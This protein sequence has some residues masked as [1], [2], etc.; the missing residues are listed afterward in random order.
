LKVGN[1]SVSMRHCRDF[2]G[3]HHVEVGPASDA[4]KGQVALTIRFGVN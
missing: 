1:V 3:F 2:E 4:S